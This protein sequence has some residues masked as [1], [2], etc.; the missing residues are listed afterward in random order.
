MLQSFYVT[1]YVYELFLRLHLPKGT[2]WFVW[3]HVTA[4][5]T[6]ERFCETIGISKLS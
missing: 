2:F 6:T 3:I 5:W 4:F 1:V